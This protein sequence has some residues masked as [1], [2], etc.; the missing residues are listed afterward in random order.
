[1][2][3]DTKT[4]DVRSH[5]EFVT[6]TGCLIWTGA[7]SAAGYGRVFHAGRMQQAHRVSWEQAN[8]RDVPAGHYV[9]HKCDTPACINPEHLFVGTPRENVIDMASKGRHWRQTD[10]CIH[11]H[12]FDAE[13]TRINSRGD[14]VCIACTRRINRDW[15]RSHRRAVGGAK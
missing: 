10:A 6:E 12:P 9:C 8:G 3:A 7:W 5:A 13:N 2:G 14:R 15:M 11:G 4:V 1:M